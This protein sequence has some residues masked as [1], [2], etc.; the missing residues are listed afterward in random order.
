MYE[1]VIFVQYNSGNRVGS[2][3]AVR[4]S[5]EQDEP[6]AVTEGLDNF[7]KEDERD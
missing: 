1:E 6:R 4:S 7:Y 5:A 2:S 3:I